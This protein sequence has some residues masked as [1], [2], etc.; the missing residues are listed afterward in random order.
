[1][2]LM[3]RSIP[4]IGQEGAEKLTRASVL[5]LGAGGV[6]AACIEAL[7][8]CGVGRIGILDHDEVSDS[9][10]NRQ[11]IALCSA[12]GKK[13]CRVAK[14]RVLDINPLCTVVEYDM[15]FSKETADS[16][17][18]SEYDYIA[19]CIDTVTSKLFLI[20]KAKEAGVPIISSMGTGNRTDPSR[21]TV[22]DVF[23]T[24]GDPLARVMRK[25]LKARGITELK[26]VFSTEEP[27]SVCSGRDKTGRATPSSIC[28]V[29]VAAGMLMAYE[30]TK[31]L[32]C[33]N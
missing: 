6:G 26:V 30:I 31:E 19:D 16:V 29:P 21:V 17:P 25:E 24:E 33:Q 9:N 12:V 28:F 7:A 2:S 5:V 3:E 11:L 10:R 1:M 8:R 32:L 23:S 22:T 4:L 15:F 13:K 20:Q 14:E 27:G 18:F